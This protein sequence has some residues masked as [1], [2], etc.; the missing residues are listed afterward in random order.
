MDGDTLTDCAI[1]F[2]ERIADEGYTPMV[3]FNLTVGYLMYDLS[4]LTDYDFWFAQ[5]PSSDAMYPTMYYNYQM[6]QYTSSGS[7]PGIEG[8]VDMNIAWKRW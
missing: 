2:S 6:W 1:A 7:V 8:N 5:Y 4:Q 3:Y